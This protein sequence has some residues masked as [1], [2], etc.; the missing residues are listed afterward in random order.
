MDLM[1]KIVYK[2]RKLEEVRNCEYEL[3]DYTSVFKLDLMR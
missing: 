1:V 3:A 2:N